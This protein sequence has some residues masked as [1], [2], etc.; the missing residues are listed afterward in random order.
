MKRTRPGEVPFFHSDFWTRRSPFGLSIQDRFHPPTFSSKR[1]H[2]VT[3][4]TNDNFIQNN[5]IRKKSH[6]VQCS[7]CFCDGLCPAFA[8][9]EFKC[10]GVQVF[11]VFFFLK[12]RL[13]LKERSQ[14]PVTREEALTTDSWRN[15]AS[16]TTSFTEGISPGAGTGRWSSQR[17]GEHTNCRTG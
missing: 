13:L 17:R 15:R 12:K 2:P 14:Q 10:L 5:F 16:R 9:R 3:L 6:V 1:F 4:S 11:R 8:R 7:P